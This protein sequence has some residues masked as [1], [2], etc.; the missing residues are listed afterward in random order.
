MGAVGTTAEDKF[1]NDMIKD[2]TAFPENDGEYYVSNSDVQSA[3]EAFVMQ[4]GGNEEKILNKIR[5]GIDKAVGTQTKPVFTTKMPSS[6]RIAAARKVLFNNTP[7]ETI[8]DTYDG[9]NY[10]QFVGMAGGDVLTYR[11]YAD[12]LIGEK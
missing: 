6:E 10:V 5:D 12:G 8:M 1:V 11:I 2:A 7:V 4:Y 9:G 3:V